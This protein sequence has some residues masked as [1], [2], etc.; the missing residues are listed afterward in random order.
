VSQEVQTG[1]CRAQGCGISLAPRLTAQDGQVGKVIQGRPIEDDV[2]VGPAE[3]EQ[4]PS[5]LC[6]VIAADGGELKW[7]P[8]SSSS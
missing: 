1:E 2:L 3:Q 6:A 4:S 7:Y 8:S 5:E